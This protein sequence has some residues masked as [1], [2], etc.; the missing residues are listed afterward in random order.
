MFNSCSTLP[1]A[2]DILVTYGISLNTYDDNWQ[3]KHKSIYEA[4][5]QYVIKFLVYSNLC[6]AVLTMLIIYRI[7]VENSERDRSTTLTK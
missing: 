4:H 6:N 2:E 5:I 1:Y 7:P 3:I